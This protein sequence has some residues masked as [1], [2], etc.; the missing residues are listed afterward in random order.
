MPFN[1]YYFPSNLQSE[2]CQC[3]G[4]G[5]GGGRNHGNENKPAEHQGGRNEI[6]IP[7]IHT[8]HPGCLKTHFQTTVLIYLSGTMRLLFLVSDS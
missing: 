7:S 3:K 2:I 8:P 6:F 5:V 4:Q 1:V